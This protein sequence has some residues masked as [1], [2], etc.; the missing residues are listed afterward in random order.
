MPKCDLSD[1][2]LA[3]WLEQNPRPDVG[4]RGFDK[5]HAKEIALRRMLF[6]GA[7]ESAVIQFLVPEGWSVQ[8]TTRGKEHSEIRV[9]DSRDR[10]IEATGK[11][12]GEALVCALEAVWA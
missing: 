6:F 8:I 5:W 4:A 11:A 3:T 2:I 10:I 7:Y 12:P 9:T 1:R